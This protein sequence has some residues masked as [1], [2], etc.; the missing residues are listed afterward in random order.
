M[1]TFDA[2]LVTLGEQAYAL[3]LLQIQEIR[4]WT[5]VSPLPS[6]DPSCLGLLNL[7]GQVLAVLDA[8]LLMGKPAPAP[9]P[10]DVIVVAVLDGKPFGLL[11]DSVSDIIIIDTEQ[12]TRAESGEAWSSRLV[13]GVA[14]IGDKLVPMIS[15][16]HIGSQQT[17][18]QPPALPQAA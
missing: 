2:L 11:V 16:Q 12:I 14:S 15:L 3:P 13:D 17:G 4:G 18:A 7:R 5:T 8:R 6:C 10:Q 1:E 9:K